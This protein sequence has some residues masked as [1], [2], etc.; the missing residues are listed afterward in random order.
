ME[1]R[2]ITL[3]QETTFP[4]SENST[5]TITEGKG[6]FNLMVRYPEWVHPGEFKVSVNGQS[7]DVITGPSSYVSINR[8]W[9]K[10]DV[11]NI[12]FPMHASLRYLPNEPQ[13]VAFMYG[14]ILLGMKPE[15]SR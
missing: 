8:K 1:K 7:V 5:L 11:V 15:Q 12:S 3:R 10:G 2:G 14:P 13:Y 9:K 6:A 4:Y